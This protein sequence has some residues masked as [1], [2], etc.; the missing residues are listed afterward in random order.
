MDPL[1]EIFKQKIRKGADVKIY[2]YEENAK[3]INDTQL[4]LKKILHSTDSHNCIL[5]NI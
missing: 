3:V 4:D 1:Y 2:K 5:I